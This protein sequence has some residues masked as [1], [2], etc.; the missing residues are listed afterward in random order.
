M[1]FSLSTVRFLGILSLGI[2]TQENKMHYD[3]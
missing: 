2:E 1:V 3:M